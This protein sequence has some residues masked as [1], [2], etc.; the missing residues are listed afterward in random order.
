MSEL[1][2]YQTGA[3]WV[4][5][6]SPVSRLPCNVLLE[7]FLSLQSEYRSDATRKGRMTNISWMRSVTHV[8]R[9]WRQWSISSPLLWTLVIAGPLRITKLFLARSH[10]LSLDVFCDI[11]TESYGED[12]SPKTGSVVVCASRARSLELRFPEDMDDIEPWKSLR[13]PRLTTLIVSKL[14]SRWSGPPPPFI[15]TMSAADLPCLR[16]LR[17]TDFGLLSVADPFIMS[18]LTKLEI[19][20]SWDVDSLEDV[21]KILAMLDGGPLEELLMEDAFPDPLCAYYDANGPSEAEVPE[22][23]PSF[24]LSI[25]LPRLKR[26]HL[27]GAAVCCETVL[28][29]AVLPSDVVTTLR[30]TADPDFGD[31]TRVLASVGQILLRRPGLETGE[32][33]VTVH[34]AE[35]CCH[36]G[37]TASV[38]T[39]LLPQLPFYDLSGPSSPTAP[40]TRLPEPQLQLSLV[41][42]KPSVIVEAL[43]SGLGTTATRMFSFADTHP[44]DHCHAGA[45][46]LALSDILAN[47]P[48]VEVISI[49]GRPAVADLPAILSS[50]LR[51]ASG[52]WTVPQLRA[53]NIGPPAADSQ[54]SIP[55]SGCDLVS[56]VDS[57]QGRKAAG[58][59]LELLRLPCDY[60]GVLSER[61][62]EMIEGCASVVEL[63]LPRAL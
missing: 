59:G 31:L 52:L 1:E 43:T 35:R 19:R 62:A 6:D 22:K 34:L 5:H 58:Y 21:M 33:P 36:N 50:P 40:S 61:Q 28:R 39:T 57:L 20:N 3:A 30:F 25:S 63:S 7:I 53:L 14:D 29:H 10:D 47:L 60:F 18:R 54:P 8:C 16:E 48:F 17:V 13:F 37:V 15:D 32:G 51:E 46:R 24:P 41:G 9:S 4:Y 26:L 11:S 2:D 42:Y 45:S 49:S 38:W 27:V 12:L 23:M 56:L 55:P 44:L